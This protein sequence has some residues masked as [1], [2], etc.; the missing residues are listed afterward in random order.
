MLRHMKRVK[1][2]GATL[3]GVNLNYVGSL[4][5]DAAIMERLDILPNERAQ[6]LNLNNGAR[7][8]TYIFPG[9]KGSGT[10]NL[11]GAAARL[12]HLG[13]KVLIVSYAL[14]TDEE[15]RTYRPTVAILDARNRI[16]EIRA[17]AGIEVTPVG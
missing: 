6:V 9:E 16:V 11:N 7:L 2:H 4:T 1:I 13:D 10:V 5:L 17:A 14:M 8:E 12:A 3:T 15:A